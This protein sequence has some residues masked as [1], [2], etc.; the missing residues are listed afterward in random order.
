MA[1]KSARKTSALILYNGKNISSSL[2]PYLKSLTVTDNIGGMADDLQITLED[3]KALWQGSWLPEMGATLDVSI[4]CENWPEL[5]GTIYRLGLFEIDEIT[6]SGPPSEVQIKA[7]SV[8]DDNKLRGVERTRSW[9]KA[10]LKRIANDIAAGAALTLAYEPDYNPIIDRAEQSEESDLN[11]LYKILQDHGL[12]LKIFDKQLVIF[13]EADYEAA[14]PTSIIYKP[15]QAGDTGTAF[16]IKAVKS[17][18]LKSKLR[19]IYKACHVK[20]QDGKSKQKIEATFTD[21]QKASGKTLE[22]N[23]QAKTQGEAERL[24]KKRLRA[25][26]CQEVTGSFSLL[27]NPLLLAANTIALNGFG[28]YD[29]T[30]IITRATHS[31]GS[32]FTT[33]IEIRRCLNGY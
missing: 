20:Y 30:Y 16:E 15:R 32:G 28:A 1:N 24:A 18:S 4:I 17:Y 9:E 19:D 26:N 13:D 3:R 27:G 23:E 31:I 21:P 2:V 11:F 6:S 12:A 22:V 10:E 8:P 29:A 7:V 25:K 33:D 5:P 14:E